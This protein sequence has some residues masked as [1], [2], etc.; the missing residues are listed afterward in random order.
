MVS[1]TAYLAKAV[2]APQG[3][4]RQKGGAVFCACMH[5]VYS[6]MR[7]AQIRF[8]V[9]RQAIDRKELGRRIIGC[10]WPLIALIWL[11]GGC[12]GNNRNAHF[13][14]FFNR[15]GKRHLIK[16]GPLIGIAI[17]KPQIIL[18]CSLHIIYGRVINWRL[19]I[20]CHL[21]FSP[22]LGFGWPRGG[23]LYLAVSRQPA[24]KTIRD[25]LNCKSHIGQGGRA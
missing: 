22:W 7:D 15:L 13:R 8:R 21:F 3:G 6:N 10:T 1:D 2:G 16:A 4:K 18:S 20:F 14:Q 24:R 17:S 9:N 5:P 25:M 12:G 11:V 23:H 19:G